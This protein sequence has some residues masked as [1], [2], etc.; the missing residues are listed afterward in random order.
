M[1]FKRILLRRDTAALWTSGNPTLASGEIGYE[2]NTGK[3]KIGNGSTAWTSLSYSNTNLPDA[4]INDLGDV[5]IAS[6]TDGDFLRW[7]GSVW[8]NDA[9]NLSTDTI[10]A[11]V[12]SLV[13]GTGISLSNN[14][15]EG[16]TPTV[17]V[18]TAVMQ[19]RVTNVSDTEIGYLDGVTSAI[20]TQIDTRAP[21]ADP[22]FTG[23]VSGITK[24]M[25]GLNNV[26]NTADANKPV[27]TAGQASLDLKSDLADPV[28]TGEPKAPTAIAGTDTTQLATTAFVRA[29]VAALVDSAPAALDTLNELAAAL[30]D[31][32]A[33]AT[34]VTNSLAEK[35]PLASPAFT[36]T[37]TGITATHVGLG[38]VDN[39]TDAAKPVS[40]AGQT[41]LDLKS[42]IASPTFTG[43]PTAP[44][45]TAATSTTQLATTAFVTTADNL[46]ANLANPT[47]TGTVGADAIVVTGRFDASTV[48]Q[49]I[50]SSSI[51]ASVMT[52]NYA[53]NDV[54]FQ[55]SA[56]TANFTLNV[57][58]APTDDDKTLTV[59]V[60]VTQGATGY[61]PSA[62]Q[63]AGVGQTI[64]WANGAAPTPT[65]SAGKIDVFSFTFIRR[66]SAWTVFGS[67]NLG[68]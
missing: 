7:N 45:A 14:S 12:E 56:P 35:A 49:V 67:S 17:A 26:N 3:F 54:H 40:T 29:E 32:A 65:S 25:V 44:T 34:T 15:G 19:A 60:F 23:T 52:A 27:S 2:S 50:L 9:V 30:G 18:D 36:G 37:P 43:V 57:T 4:S 66:A 20:Q 28:F 13:A 24:A 55:A 58:N 33:F 61:I 11:Y 62:V 42:N 8:I 53:T 6:A 31:D 39:T 38:S 21:I 64:K 63:V 41:A 48:R 22:V 68:Y 10:G 47:F 1:A 46:K 51:S 59:V 5:T 16:A